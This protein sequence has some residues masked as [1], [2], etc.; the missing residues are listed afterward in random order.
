V[1]NFIY[2]VISDALRY[3][4]KLTRYEVSLELVQ[5]DVKGTVETKRRRDGRD[6]L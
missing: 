5:V 6:N 1:G 2:V 3:L 4:V